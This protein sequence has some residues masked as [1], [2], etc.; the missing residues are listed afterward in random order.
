MDWAGNYDDATL[1][2]FQLTPAER[3]SESV[4]MHAAFAELTR[5]E[6]RRM[7]RGDDTLMPGEFRRRLASLQLPAARRR[8]IE[9]LLVRHDERDNNAD[10]ATDDG[11]LRR[12]GK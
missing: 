12:D 7:M 9:A 8:V 4:R 1:R 6:Q 5:G 10:G 2:W 11:G 3:W